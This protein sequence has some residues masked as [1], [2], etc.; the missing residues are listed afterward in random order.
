MAET[1]TTATTTSESATEQSQL[2]QQV[3]ITDKGPCLKH[4]KVTIRREIIDRMVEEKLGQL[5]QTVPL[6]GFRPGKAPA[7]LVRRYLEPQALEEIRP[8]L[9]VASLEQILEQY[10]LNP[11]TV[12][13]FDPLSVAIPKEGPLVYE[14]DLEVWPEFPLPNYKGMKLKR[15]VVQITDEMVRRERD[16]YIR[17]LA[18]QLVPKEVVE[19][20]DLIVGK[21]TVTREDRTVGEF[22]VRLECDQELRFQDGVVRNFRDLV[23]GAKPGEVRQFTI[24]LFRRNRPQELTGSAEATLEIREIYRVHVPDSMEEIL[25]GLPFESEEEL[26][27]HVREALERRVS[28]T[29][30]DAFRAQIVHLWSQEVRPRLPQSVLELEYR[31]AL[32]RRTLELQ[33]AGY[34]PEEINRWSLVISRQTA[35][36]VWWDLYFQM[37]AQKIAEVEKIEVEQEE[38]D[39]VIELLARSLGESPRRM[40]ARFERSKELESIAAMILQ[41]KVL[42]FIIEHAEIEDVP[43]ALSEGAATVLDDFGEE[44]KLLEAFPSEPSPQ[45]EPLTGQESSVASAEGESGKPDTAA[46]ETP[47]TESPSPTA[48]EKS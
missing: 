13:D 28:R 42:D 37:I 11:I 21:L 19:P 3:E 9:L 32:T 43:G 31:R 14:F 40:R 16:N 18:G 44:V 36:E 12:P 1:Q 39:A 20:G 15:P 4:I 29:Q 34:T 35:N 17:R 48:S 47:S 27:Q 10:N 8:T 22:E 7:K 26:V 38:V 46:Q 45:S 33:A 25:A 30:R 6:P 24:E 41:N 5:G 2:E 23:V